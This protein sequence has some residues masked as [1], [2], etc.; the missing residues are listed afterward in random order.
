MCEASCKDWETLYQFYT[1]I[2]EI[3]FRLKVQWS[4]V[5]GHTLPELHFR[6]C[7]ERVSLVLNGVT[8][9]PLSNRICFCI[10]RIFID[11]PY[12]WTLSLVHYTINHLSFVSLWKKWS[13]WGVCEEILRRNSWRGRK[14]VEEITEYFFSVQSS[15]REVLPL[16]GHLCNMPLGA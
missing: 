5:S 1:S 14:H 7:F 12:I 2:N 4:V 13:A 3:T 10:L 8:I 16:G 15:F 6:R 9:T 11:T